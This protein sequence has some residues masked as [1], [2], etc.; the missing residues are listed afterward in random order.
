MHNL[1]FAHRDIKLQNILCSE[2][3]TQ[4]KIADFGFVVQDKESYISSRLLGTQPYLAPEIVM[5][6]ANMKNGAWVEH[7][8]VHH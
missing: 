1:K 4:M 5:K 2:E 3:G 6:C 8:G 7:E